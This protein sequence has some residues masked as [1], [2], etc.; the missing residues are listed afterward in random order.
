M[1]LYTARYILP[2]TVSPVENGE[3]A[4]KNGEIVA[5]GEKSALKAE[6]PDAKLHNLGN[7]A[8]LPGLINAHVHLELTGLGPRKNVSRVSFPFWLLGLV[9]GTRIR[10]VRFFKDSISEGLKL[11]RQSGTTTAGHIVTFVKNP[12]ELFNSAGLRGVLFLEMIGLK[13]EDADKIIEGIET[14]I[15]ELQ[16]NEMIIPAI[17]PHAPY[18]VSE[19]LF[20]RSSELSLNK[21]IPITIHLAESIDEIKLL[22]SNRGK[23]KKIFYPLLGLKKYSPKGKGKTPVKYLDEN[24][25]LGENVSAVHCVHLHEEDIKILSKKSVSVILC[26]RSNYYLN[27]GKAPVKQLYD[28]GVNLCLATDGLV[29]NKSLSLWDEARFLKEQNHWIDSESILKMM[30]T[31]PARALNIDKIGSLSAGKLADFIAVDI[32]GYNGGNIYDFLIQ[33]TTEEKIK[34]VW[35]SGRKIL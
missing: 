10:T 15:N 12:V 30:T 32:T 20:R 24:G 16:N 29:S 35:V 26:P 2:L 23:F 33:N 6:Y 17:S 9:V 18:S 8:I 25:I 21:K 5:A 34:G 1:E 28:S 14:Q 7:V 31:N 13:P 11:L 3:L 27:V 22:K 4:I 19:E